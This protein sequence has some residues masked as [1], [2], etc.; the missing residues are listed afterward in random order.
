MTWSSDQSVAEVKVP[1]VINGYK[2]KSIDKDYTDLTKVD[3]VTLKH[4]DSDYTV[5]VTYAKDEN[6]STPNKPVVP[7]PT[8]TPTPTPEP[9]PKPQPEPNPSTP[10]NPTTP[11][12]PETP[13]PAPKPETPVVPETPAPK[14]ETPKSPEEPVAPAPKPEAPVR[15]VEN[16]S[17]PVKA[18]EAPK[19]EAK[20]QKAT[21][22]Q[23]GESS[24]EAATAAGL[25][26]GLLG[27]LGL[28]EVD[29]KKRRKH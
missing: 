24:N 8:T 25:F 7:P 11:E 16:I 20:A 2:V 22:P 10:E 4:G 26:T 9:S 5:T 19:V 18:A 13:A 14:P 28:V 3:S 1:E 15:P 12:V 21:L 6:P 29:K 27:L 17:T 23:T